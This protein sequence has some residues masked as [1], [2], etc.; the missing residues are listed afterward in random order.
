MTLGPEI[1]KKTLIYNH[2]KTSKSLL[3]KHYQK[4]AAIQNVRFLKLSKIKK[5][6]S[7]KRI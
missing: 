5:G 4:K 1:E 7:G 6:F 3:K 2:L